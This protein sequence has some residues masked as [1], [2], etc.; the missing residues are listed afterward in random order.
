MVTPEKWD[1][2]PTFHHHSMIAFAIRTNKTKPQYRLAHQISV[3]N[4]TAI[5]N[6]FELDSFQYGHFDRTHN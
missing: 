6:D 2:G 1:R 5:K 3:R 4:G